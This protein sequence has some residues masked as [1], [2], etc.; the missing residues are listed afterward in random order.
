MIPFYFCFQGSES[1]L[2]VRKSPNGP[3]A[4]GAHYRCAFGRKSFVRGLAPPIVRTANPT[5]TLRVFG[6]GS[7]F[8]R[9]ARPLTDFQTN[10]Y[11][12]MRAGGFLRYHLF[13]NMYS[14]NLFVLDF[15]RRF[16]VSCAQIFEAYAVRTLI[17]FGCGWRKIG[18]KSRC[19]KDSEST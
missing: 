14:R 1:A 5:H 18:R 13:T 9:Y 3:K 4:T 10:T 17:K 8:C 19:M 2:M 6:H 15:A 11:S 12:V 7:P 16:F